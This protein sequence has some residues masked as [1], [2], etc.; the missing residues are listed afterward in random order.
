MSEQ[1]WFGYG[2]NCYLLY[3]FD[4]LNITEERQFCILH[5]AIF[6]FVLDGTVCEQ[7]WLG[8]GGNC[9]LFY[10]DNVLNFSDARQLL[11]LT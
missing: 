8:Y 2:R 5:K 4:V 6:C 7:G 11:G 9:Y 10:T 1:V 3:T